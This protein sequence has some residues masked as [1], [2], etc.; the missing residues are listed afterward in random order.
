MITEEQTQPENAPLLAL[1]AAALAASR[2]S[3]LR[4][5]LQEATERLSHV[6]G[7]E[8]CSLLV[9]RDGQFWGMGAVGLP[10]DY[11]DAIDGVPI[12]PE[13]GTCGKA[14]ALGRTCVTPDIREDP[15]WAEFLSLA[16]AA[17]LRAC[18]SVPLLG[19]DGEPLATF[20]TYS[21]RALHALP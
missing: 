5:Y 20:A 14:A 1:K 7:A 17:G 9:A 16:D 13:V 8:S 11:V 3:S 10:Q 18:W 21:A 6:V 4:D 15:N 12:G 2:A 19:S